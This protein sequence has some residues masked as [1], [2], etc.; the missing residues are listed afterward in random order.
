MEILGQYVEDDRAALHVGLHLLHQGK[1]FPE[2]IVDV[3]RNASGQVRERVLPLDLQHAGLEIFQAAV[4]L[5][6]APAR[7]R[8]ITIARIP[9]GIAL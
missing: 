7:M 6:A 9:G 5:G 3:V 8:L 2:R 4:N 1:D